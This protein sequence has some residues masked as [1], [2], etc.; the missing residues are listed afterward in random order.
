MLYTNDFIMNEYNL[1]YDALGCELEFNDNMLELCGS[2]LKDRLLPL[3]IEQRN[4][5]IIDNLKNKDE[6]PINPIANGFYELND[7][8]ILIQCY[9]IEV[10]LSEEHPIADM[11]NVTVNDNKT[12]GYITTG[13]GFLF[14]VIVLF[15]Q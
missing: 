6:Q 7:N 15:Y 4:E 5:F 2:K 3:T 9:E 8:E 13:Q 11:D 10:E 12:F 14:E 1:T